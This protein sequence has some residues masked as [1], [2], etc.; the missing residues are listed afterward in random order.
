MKLYGKDKKKIFY[1]LVTATCWRAPALTGIA[2][3]Q[4][5]LDI[6]KERYVP[7]IADKGLGPFPQ[8]NSLD[9]RD[10]EKS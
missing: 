7:Q 9:W 4:Y 6:F 2:Q 5:M 1:R 3:L 10:E 8:K